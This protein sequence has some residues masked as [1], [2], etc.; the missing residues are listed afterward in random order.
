MERVF[1][2]FK[3]D[4][5]IHLASWVIISSLYC[6]FGRN[7][8]HSLSQGMSGSAMLNPLCRHINVTATSHLIDLC[9]EWDCC[10]FIYT[11][12]YNVIFGGNEII[13]GNED[14]DYFP[15]DKYTDWYSR[16]KSETEQ[17]VLANSGKTTKGGPNPIPFHFI[18]IDNKQ[19]R[20]SIREETSN[21]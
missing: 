21:L 8:R 6:L 15:L 3:P 12:T 7:K 5:V 11:S 9:T 19:M 1:V 14:N 18:L 2:S 16:S 10:N 17:L 4:V 20:P 13:N